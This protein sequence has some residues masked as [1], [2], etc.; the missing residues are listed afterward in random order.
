MIWEPLVEGVQDL[1]IT[2]K[3]MYFS[4]EDYEDLLALYNARKGSLTTGNGSED[5]LLR[6]VACTW[7]NAVPTG[8]PSGE[9]NY[10]QWSRFLR[11]KQKLM[12]GGIFPMKGDKFRAPELLPGEARVE[13]L[14]ILRNR[15]K[16][17]VIK[18]PKT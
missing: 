17:R 13:Y 5:D 16:G 7:M 18:L 15:I 12:I 4:L 1:Y 6:E 10:E 8:S 14:R 2:M 9:R 3:N 11:T